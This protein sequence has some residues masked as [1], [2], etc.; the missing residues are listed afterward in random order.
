MGQLGTKHSYSD[1]TNGVN[2][3]ATRHNGTN[4]V[5]VFFE[6][7]WKESDSTG[8]Y[9]FD[10][11]NPISFA[12]VSL[13]KKGLFQWNMTGYV[14]LA[15]GTAVTEFQ[16]LAPSLQAQLTPLFELVT[17]M[18]ANLDRDLSR[19]SLYSSREIVKL[20]PPPTK[21]QIAVASYTNADGAVTVANPFLQ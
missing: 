10:R 17:Q 6:S 19:L 5:D 16:N 3:T 2:V 8:V 13:E 4:M 1:S 11:Q 18:A 12:R 14:T 20:L 7:A 15:D 21:T 9:R